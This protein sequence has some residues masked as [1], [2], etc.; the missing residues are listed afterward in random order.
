MNL[1]VSS[2]EI[3]NWDEV[4]YWVEFEVNGQ[5]LEIGTTWA[6]GKCS[7]DDVIAHRGYSGETTV[8]HCFYCGRSFTDCEICPEF[9]FNS[10]KTRI[11]ADQLVVL[12]EDELKELPFNFDNPFRDTNRGQKLAKM[13][14][15]ARER[16]DKIAG[17]FDDYNQ[18]MVGGS[19]KAPDYDSPMLLEDDDFFFMETS[20]TVVSVADNSD[21][22][23]TGEVG[24]FESEDIYSY[25]VP[26]VLLDRSNQF[27]ELE[28]EW[29]KAKIL[30]TLEFADLSHRRS[31]RIAF[32]H[33]MIINNFPKDGL[34]RFVTGY[35]TVDMLEDVSEIREAFNNFLEDEK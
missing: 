13:I 7:F 26:E 31:S 20:Y 1:T 19:A 28:I 18:Y 17:I 25:L 3:K 4:R 23:V 24:L 12:L 2:A 33:S 5:K 32:L 15:F 35:L 34:S 30:E 21:T 14:K 29:K 8:P 6:D 10:V 27:E 22:T 11:I 16:G 9:Y